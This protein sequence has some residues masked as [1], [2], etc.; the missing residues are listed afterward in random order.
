MELPASFSTSLF[1]WKALS[2]ADYICRL[3]D[4]TL[5]IEQLKNSHWR[6]GVKEHSG[7]AVIAEVKQF[8]KALEYVQEIYLTLFNLKTPPAITSDFQYYHY[9]EILEHYVTIKDV[10]HYTELVTEIHKWDELNK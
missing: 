6:F 5:V 1:P 8:S 9:C 10:T 7:V 4:M 3:P 2:S